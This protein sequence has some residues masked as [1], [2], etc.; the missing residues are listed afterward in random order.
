MTRRTLFLAGAAALLPAL[1]SVPAGSALAETV[2]RQF[3][4]PSSGLILT[5]TVY[6][7]LADGK[8]IVVSRRY[9]IRF[10]PDAGGYR[11]DGEQIGV[12]VDVPQVLTGMAEIERKRVD[13]S[14]FPTWLDS[15]GIVRGQSG[16]GDPETR[17]LVF[18]QARLALDGASA[19]GAAKVERTAMLNQ[20]NNASALSSW[21]SDLYNPGSGERVNKRK[22]P[23]PDG[24]EG[25]VEVRV[26]AEGLMPGGMA[27]KVERVVTTR[28]EGT[29]RIS[30]EVWL[31]SHE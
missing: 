29:T 22:V 1:A 14:L 26:H 12:E 28:L 5:R 19:P 10:T 4:P 31:L 9:A 24:S 20:L 18:G 6:R 13:K 25:E 15:R 2:A 8:Q 30:R 3:V 23:L 16:A 21:P 27:Q 11:L 7:T 17:K